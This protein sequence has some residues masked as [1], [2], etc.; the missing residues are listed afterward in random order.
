MNKQQIAAMAR[1]G[2]VLATM[3]LTGPKAML[4]LPAAVIAIGFMAPPGEA[5]GKAPTVK[6]TK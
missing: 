5:E 4:T 3:R 2:A 1:K 6:G